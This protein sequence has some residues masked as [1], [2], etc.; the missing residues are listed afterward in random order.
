MIHGE[1]MASI[2]RQLI[3]NLEEEKHTCAE[4]RLS[5]YS[6]YIYIYNIIN[7]RYG[8]KRDEWAKLA[9]WFVENKLASTNV[10]YMIQVPR[11]YNVYKKTGSVENLQQM[12]DNLFIPLFENTLNPESNKELYIFLNCVAGFDSVDDESIVDSGLDI[13]PDFTPD[14]WN[15][16]ENPAYFYW[17]YFMYANLYT[18]NQFRKDH[19]MSIISFRPHCGEAGDTLHLASTFLVAESINHGINLQDNTP[20][21]YLYF[22]EQIG[23]SVSPL[24][25]NNL[26]V[27]LRHNPFFKFFKRGMKVTLSTDDPLILHHSN[28]PLLE[29]YYSAQQQWE[30]SQCDLCEIARNSVLMS[31]FEFPFKCYF[32]GPTYYLDGPDGNNLNLTNVPDIRLSFRDYILKR[33]TEIIKMFSEYTADNQKSKDVEFIDDEIKKL[34]DRISILEKKKTTIQTK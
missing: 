3:T 20:L 12:L 19:H 29:E 32:S 9:H 16:L 15:L 5:V 31:G 26:F 7:N 13:T 34:Q 25:N 2:T 11:I 17:M 1:Y 27:K 8:R 28:D 33:E 22:L 10:R 24:S 18:L 4:Y 14:K 30:L 21:Q 23:L 6:I